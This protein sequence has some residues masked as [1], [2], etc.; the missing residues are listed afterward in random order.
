MASGLF[1]LFKYESPV[2]PSASLSVC[3]CAKCGSTAIFWALYGLVDGR[4][5]TVGQQPFI[6]N[7]SSWGAPGVSAAAAPGRVHVTVVRDPISRYLSAFA[8]KVKCCPGP[9]PRRPCYSDQA[10]PNL[11]QKLLKQ[12]GSRTW[13]ASGACLFL[14]EFAAALDDAHSRGRHDLNGHFLPQH[15]ACPSRLLRNRTAVSYTN[16]TARLVN[17]PTAQVYVMTDVARA[18]K[19]L[20]SVSWLPRPHPDFQ[21]P[22]TGRHASGQDSV[23]SFWLSHSSAMRVL[24]RVSLDEYRALQLP[25]PE[26][27][28]SS[29]GV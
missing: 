16:Q 22:V 10:S 23:E 11:V 25:V 13:Q 24:C 2:D 18:L 14:D 8:S 4:P 21:Q 26:R 28:G 5:R 29:S 17:N 20:R 15:L 1:K 3:V 12:S 7:F 9:V 27:C 19:A 6:H